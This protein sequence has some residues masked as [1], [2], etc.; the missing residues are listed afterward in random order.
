MNDPQDLTPPVDATDEEKRDPR[1]GRTAEDVRNGWSFEDWLAYH[2]QRT[3]AA[4]E[5]IDPRSETRRRGGRPDRAAGHRWAF[6][7]RHAW[8][9]RRRFTR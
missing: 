4:G 8:Q 5:R 3:Q 9:S 2:K 7:A 6:P 1:D